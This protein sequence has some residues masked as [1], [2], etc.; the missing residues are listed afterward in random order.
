MENRSMS[1]PASDLPPR[2]RRAL[3]LVYAVEGV[4]EARV[5]MSPGKVSVGVRSQSLDAL[6]RVEHAVLPLKE[7]GEE[8]SFGWME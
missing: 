3:E 7:P 5:W 4:A 1:E 2:L 8:W 6:S